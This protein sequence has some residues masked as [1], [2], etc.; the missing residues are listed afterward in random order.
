MRVYLDS[1]I[2]IYYI[3]GHPDHFHQIDESLQDPDTEWVVSDLCKLE[4]LVQPMRL[5]DGQ[6]VERYRKF[7]AAVDLCT[8]ACTT[9]VF[10]QATELRAQHGLKTP[11]ALHLASAITGGC[12]DFWTNDHRLDLA[13]GQYLR[14]IVLSSSKD[15]HH[16]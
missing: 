1:C 15:P 2:L 12:T 16:V 13:A 11:D 5:Q 7:F 4:C 14:T 6:R 9:A 8:L 10:E 3:D